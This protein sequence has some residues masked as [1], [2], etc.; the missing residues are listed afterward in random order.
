VEAA[1]LDLRWLAPL[2]DEA[3]ATVVEATGRVLVLRAND[4]AFAPR[5]RRA[6]TSA[7]ST[8]ARRGRALGA[9]DTPDPVGAKRFSAR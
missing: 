7:A 4:G 5:S 2:D 6:S 9:P 8:R 3:I 1:V